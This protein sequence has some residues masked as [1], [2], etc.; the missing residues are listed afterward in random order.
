[1]TEN[2]DFK[3]VCHK[4]DTLGTKFDKLEGKLDRNIEVSSERLRQ[5]EM[6]TA[7]IE[8]GMSTICKDVDILNDKS[9]RN[10]VIVAVG[11]MIVVAAAS[12][13]A[14]LGLRNE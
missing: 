9:N 3:V 12:V 14:A 2:A 1:M 4:I 10:D 5:L 13:A 8:N 7:V 11:N 6:Q